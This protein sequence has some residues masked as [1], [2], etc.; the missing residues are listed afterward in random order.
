MKESTGRVEWGWSRCDWEKDNELIRS[1]RN[2]SRDREYQGRWTLQERNV[3]VHRVRELGG[4][5]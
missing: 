2:V 3:Q 4:K 5:K 1:V